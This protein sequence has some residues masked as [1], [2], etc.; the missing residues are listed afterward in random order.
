MSIAV[1]GEPKTR[2]ERLAATAAEYTE[3][4]H[5]QRTRR[6][7]AASE[8][9][10]RFAAVTSEGSPESTYAQNGN[11]IVADTVEALAELVR[12][13]CDEGWLA[14]GRVWDL[15]GPWNLWGNLAGAYLVQVGRT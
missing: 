4:I 14:H 2:R 11:L 1:A 5:E 10:S 8:A 13:E 12:Q 15:D 9:V 3:E 7:L 6:Q